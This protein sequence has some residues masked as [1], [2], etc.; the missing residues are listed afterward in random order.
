M[1]KLIYMASDDGPIFTNQLIDLINSCPLPTLKTN[2]FRYLWIEESAI[3]VSCPSAK[4][5]CKNSA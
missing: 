3:G 5:F 1:L 2:I 4:K